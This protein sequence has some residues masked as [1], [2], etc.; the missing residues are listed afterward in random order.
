MKGLVG[1]KLMK[2]YNN[3]DSH[4]LNVVL[5]LVWLSFRAK[6]KKNDK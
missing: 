2:W 3:I 1:K 5:M 4:N 6:D